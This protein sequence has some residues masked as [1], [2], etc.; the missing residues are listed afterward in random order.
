MAL[1]LFHF[2]LLHTVLEQIHFIYE[3]D[4]LGEMVLRSISAALN[5]EGGTLFCLRADN[6][7]QPIASHGVS[8]DRLKLLKFEV[9]IGVVGWVVKHGQGVKVDTPAQ[10]QRFAGSVDVITG[11]KTK[12][13]LAAPVLSKGRVVGVIEFLNRKDGPFS[14]PD[15]ELVS[16]LGRE[17]GIA[18]ENVALIRE[19]RKTRALLDAMTDSFSAGIIVVDQHRRFLRLNVSAL[20]ML[21]VKEPEEQWLMKPMEKLFSEGTP[22]F[23]ALQGAIESKETKSRL[24]FRMTLNGSERVIGYSATPVCDKSGERLGSAI[25]FQDITAYVKPAK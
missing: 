14:I 25:L 21:G 17:V 7:L 11:F 12:N 4:Q 13:I 10:D 5:A 18:F 24:E 2:Q 20:K 22:L 8:L 23:G 15:M 16:M 6:S 19:L 1:G 9:G 3:E